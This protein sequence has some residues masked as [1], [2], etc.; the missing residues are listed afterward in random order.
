M[1]TKRGIALI[2]TLALCTG[3]VGCTDANKKVVT[4][5]VTTKEITTD[6]V[7]TDEIVTDEVATDEIVTDEVVAPTDATV[8]A[9]TVVAK[10][11]KKAPTV[12]P[13]K[14]TK[15]PATPATPSAPAKPN[16]PTTPVVQPTTPS[17]PPAFVPVDVTAMQNAKLYAEQ[18]L[19]PPPKNTFI[20]GEQ[21]PA[22]YGEAYIMHN[23]RGW[24]ELTGSYE[25]DTYVWELN[26][27]DYTPH[28]EL[29]KTTTVNLVVNSGL[30]PMPTS[31]PATP[32]IG[33]TDG[34]A[35]FDAWIWLGEI[36]PAP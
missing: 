35:S 30:Y 26:I 11:D 22:Q 8:V 17:A 9:P 19:N 31:I 10:D 28:Y 7:A 21:R 25:T 29:N 2:V 4:K 32:M 14:D 3:L 12:A 16:A 36:T 18:T 6:E 23:I 15:V 5:D 33:Q 13:K 27:C 24:W 20:M 1:K 34:R